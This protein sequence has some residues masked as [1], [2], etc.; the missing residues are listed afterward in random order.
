MDYLFFASNS[1]C[2]A[3]IVLL[4]FWRMSQHHSGLLLRHWVISILSG[5]VFYVLNQNIFSQLAIFYFLIN[6]AVPVIM[7][8]LLF[9][10]MWPSRIEE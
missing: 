2:F 6:T 7:L 4:L 10:L 8:I 3:L 9:A 1:V 5:M